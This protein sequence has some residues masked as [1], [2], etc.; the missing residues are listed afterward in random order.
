MFKYF[1]KQIDFLIARKEKT[2]D[3]NQNELLQDTLFSSGLKHNL[4]ELKTILNAS[5]DVA[6]REFAFGHKN[7]LNAA[8]VYIDGLISEDKMNMNI[9]KPLMHDLKMNHDTTMNTDLTPEVIKKTWLSAID[10]ELTSSLSDAINACLNGYT[11][12]IIDGYGMVLLIDTKGWEQR[13]I[14]E[15]N[16]ENVIR[17]SREG[18]IEDLGTNISLLRRKIKNPGLTFE[19]MKIGKQTR[20]IVSFVY[21]KGITDTALVEEVRSR[22]KKIKTDAIL[23][24]GYIEQ[25]IEDDMFSLFPTIGNSEKPDVV[26]AKMLEGRIAILT[27]GASTV[28]TAPAL[29]IESMQMSEDYYSRPYFASFVRMIRLLAFFISFLAPAIYIALTTFNQEVIPTPLLISL[30]ASKDGTPFPST[31]EAIMMTISYEILREASI[32]LPRSV[33]S[34]ISIVGGLIL[35]EAAVSAGLIGAPMVIVISL[36]AITSFIN[37]PQYETTSILRIFFIFCASITGWFGIALGV[38][39]L[40]FYMSSLKS[41]GVPYL[42]PIAPLIPGDLKDTLIRF[43]WPFLTTRPLAIAPQNLQRISSDPSSMKQNNGSDGHA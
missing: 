30:V 33:G 2:S 9:I 39:F 35:G 31:M 7:E 29:F 5:S 42:S 36:M 12:M 37:P 20:T 21:I 38:L 23:E 15:P 25:L 13:S 27:D 8:L 22:L 16:T 26:A 19:T 41:F 1:F 40:Y 11:L 24:S 18:F 32:R 10:V 14:E 3:S 43:P 17:G 6:F 28:L 34:A 4:N